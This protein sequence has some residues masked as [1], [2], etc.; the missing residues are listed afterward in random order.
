MD[1]FKPYISLYIKN[2]ESWVAIL[3]RKTE[4]SIM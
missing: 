4:A 1:N 3:D 2:R